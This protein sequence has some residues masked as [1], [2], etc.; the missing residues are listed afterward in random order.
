MKKKQPK[1]SS[2]S[3]RKRVG[4]WGERVWPSEEKTQEFEF[5]G[6]CDSQL[7]ISFLEYLEP[8]EEPSWFRAHVGW[9]DDSA[10]YKDF[11]SKEE[12][13]RFFIVYKDKHTINLEE[14]AQNWGFSQY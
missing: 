14:L 8:S 11:S 12:L 9:R 7:S 3:F 2:F 5:N 1:Y 6:S 13:N 10:Y 4:I